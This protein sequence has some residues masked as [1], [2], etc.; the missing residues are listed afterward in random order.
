MKTT[1][2]LATGIIFG[3]VLSGI[4]SILDF[5]TTYGG[6]VGAILVGTIIGRLVDEGPIR[7]GFISIF[8][9][10]LIAFAMLALFDP[11]AKIVF[12]LAPEYKAVVGLFVGFMIIVI[13]FYSIIGSF[14]AFVTYN[15][16]TDK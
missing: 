16:R 9:Y 10:N 7:H 5:D 11:D 13:V 8:A 14:S 12:G 3:L 15:M 1:K 6:L 4:F 2:V